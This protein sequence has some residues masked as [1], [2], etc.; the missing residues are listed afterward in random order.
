MS[1]SVCFT[2]PVYKYEISS[3]Q[4]T[5]FRSTLSICILLIITLTAKFI[6]SYFLVSINKV[7]FFNEGNIPCRTLL[8]SSS[9]GETFVILW[10][11]C[12]IAIRNY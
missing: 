3:F 5:A 10:E 8:N 9:A 2:C 12:D 11:K 7:A 4:V 6:F 1:V